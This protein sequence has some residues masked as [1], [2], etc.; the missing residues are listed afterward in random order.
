MRNAADRGREGPAIR[1]R[2]QTLGLIAE[3]RQI[4]GRYG[5]SERLYRRALTLAEAAFPD[6]LETAALL[7]GLGVLHKYQG[8]YDEAEPVYRRALAIVEATLGPDY[9]EAASRYDNLRGL[10]QVRARARAVRP[11]VG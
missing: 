8:R 11:W 7:N 6:D 1:L 4:Q 5:A 9:P 2:V 10:D 3:R